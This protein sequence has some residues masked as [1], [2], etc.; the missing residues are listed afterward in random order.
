MLW[1]QKFLDCL[2]GFAK[3]SDEYN[4]GSGMVET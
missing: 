3:V 4:G 2:V 1:F